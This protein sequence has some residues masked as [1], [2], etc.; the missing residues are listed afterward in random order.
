MQSQYRYF[1]VSDTQKAWGLYATCAGRGR[2]EPGAEFPSRNHPDEYYFTWER[3]R[4]LGEWQ[5]ILLMEGRGE[6]GFRE[7]SFPLEAGSLLA[8]APG[9][10]HRYRPDPATG[11]TTLWIG[12]GGDEA[13]RLMECVGLGAADGS[14]ALTATRSLRER[15]AATVADLIDDGQERVYAASARLFTLLAELKELPPSGGGTARARREAMVRQARAYIAEHC[16]GVVDF[17][18]L[19]ESLGVPYRTFRHIFK[20]ECGIPPLRYQLETRL[21]RALNLL[22]S[23][24]MSVTEIAS[25]LGF[26]SAWHFSHFFQRETGRSATQYRI[27]ATRKQGADGGGALRQDKRGGQHCDA[28]WDG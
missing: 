21:A 13:K 6:V 14:R 25:L 28:K 10:W 12:F 11:W 20:K 22:A 23:S 1:P 15:F 18:S 8:L 26:H 5:L 24:D 27:A 4:I 17:Q 19:A 9:C 7:G 3:G 16:G 2:S